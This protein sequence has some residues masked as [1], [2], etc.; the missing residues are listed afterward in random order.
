VDG[1]GKLSIEPSLTIYSASDDKA[2]LIAHLF[3]CNELEVDLSR[4][5]EI[6][7]AGCQLLMLL[8]RVADAAGKGLR[9]TGHSPA[10]LEA[11]DTYDLAGYFGD[12]LVIT[13]TE[14]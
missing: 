9:F 1:K 4:I 10:V 7:T 3:Q 14:G 13:K 2:P 11:W 6:D 12:P 8:K 5:S